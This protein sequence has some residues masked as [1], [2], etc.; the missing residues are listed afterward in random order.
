MLK[1]IAIGGGE[2]GRPGYPV[3]TTKIDQEIIRLSGKKHPQ[4][5]FV[6]T[7]SGDAEIYIETAERHFGKKLGC[8]VDSLCLIRG[9]LTAAEISEKILNSDI[10]YVGGGDTTMMM[11]I[12]RKFG[13]DRILKKACKKSIV[14]CGVSAGSVCWFNGAERESKKPEKQKSR[15]F[16]QKGLGFIDAL[17]C[18]HYDI[19]KGSLKELVRRN[20]VAIALQNCCALE[21]VGNEYRIITSKRG[22]KA[23]KVFWSKGIFYEIIIVEQKGFLPLASLLKKRRGKIVQ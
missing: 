14:L 22:K 11:K 21:I 9:K 6:P 5:L 2:I 17:H 15:H 10:I 7:A 4:L 3:E 16:K 12:W 20:G 8:K 18:P 1:I 23:Y 19:K 13:V